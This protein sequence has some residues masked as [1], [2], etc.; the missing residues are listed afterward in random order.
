MSITGQGR[1][2]YQPDLA[3]ITLG[4]QVDKAPTA[5]AALKQLNE[6]MPKIIAAILP[7]GIPATDIQTQSYTLNPQYDFP[8]G[9]TQT[10]SGYNANQQL[11]VKARNIAGNGELV[12]KVI[13]E[14]G[15]AGA[16]QVLGVNFSVEKLNDLKQQA[17]LKAL[18]DAQA[19]VA[20]L[21][22]AAGV[23]KIGKVT[24]WYEN[25]IQSPDVPAPGYGMGGGSST[26][27][28]PVGT[29]EIV[30]EVGLNYEVK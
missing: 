28:L 27:Q 1:V 20:P 26:P 16:N 4:I 24:G 18:A 29:Q 7:L 3:T 5:E 11:S 10:L 30:V 8:E 13:A 25:F 17:R 21:A 22:K 12:G 6:T 15:K 14:A 9:G 19:K 23:R 2:T